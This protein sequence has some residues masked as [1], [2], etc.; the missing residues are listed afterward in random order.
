MDKQMTVIKILAICGTLLTWFPILI[1][2]ILSALL[3]GLTKFDYLLPAELFIISLIGILMLIGAAFWLRIDPRPPITIACVAFGVLIFG[4]IV[5][6]F[7]EHVVGIITSGSF[8]SNFIMVTVII[9]ILAVI[10]LG[11][12]GIM[13]TIN[14][15]RDDD[16]PNQFKKHKKYRKTR[17]PG[18][19]SKPRKIKN[20]PKPSSDDD[21]DNTPIL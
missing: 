11:V 8:I 15:F 20:S 10:V 5:A 18:K 12:M 21:F 19:P 14:L 13:L 7:S 17:K 16:K 9:Y 6:A 3:T 1:T 2:P 4:Q